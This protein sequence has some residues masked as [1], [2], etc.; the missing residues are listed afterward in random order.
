MAFKEGVGGN[1]SRTQS[2]VEDRRQTLGDGLLPVNN[3]GK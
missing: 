3:P 2:L 1:H